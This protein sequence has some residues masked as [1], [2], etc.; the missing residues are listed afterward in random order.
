LTRQLNA[1]S[2]LN[3]A[4]ATANAAAATAMLA[5]TATGRRNQLLRGTTGMLHY[6]RRVRRV[7]TKRWM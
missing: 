5:T 3:A 4:D 2:R 6:I 7:V 1:L